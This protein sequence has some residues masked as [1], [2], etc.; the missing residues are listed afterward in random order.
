L[1]TAL[2]H[3]ISIVTLINRGGQPVSADLS[4]I[5]A[6]VNEKGALLPIAGKSISLIDAYGLQAY[7]VIGYS[8]VMWRANSTTLDNDDHADGCYGTIFG[9][10][11]H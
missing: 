9:F 10:I 5:R 1:T 3:D 11:L 7:S 6:A 2:D 8:Y 4:S